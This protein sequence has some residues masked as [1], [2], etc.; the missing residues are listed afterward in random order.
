MSI[1]DSKHLFWDACVIV[2]WLTESPTDYVEH[3]SQYI[4]EASRNER[5]IYISTVSFAEVRPS[6]LKKKDFGTVNDLIKAF[7]S[8]FYPINPTPD[9]M[10]QAGLLKDL[11]FKK[12]GGTSR[13]VGTGD[14]IQLTTCL[15]A[16]LEL[17]IADI[18][19]HTFDEGKGKNWEGKC[20]PLLGFEDWCEGHQSNPVVKRVIDLSR[21]KPEHPNP[22]MI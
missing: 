8:A 10:T 15:Y 12:K 19:F 13:V 5:K 16:K 20:V 14:A 4:Q 17:G 7:K 9:I 11:V 6:F 2:R 21:H 3:I 22:K 1:P 18:V